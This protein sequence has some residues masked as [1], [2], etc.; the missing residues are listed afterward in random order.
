MHRYRDSIFD[1]EKKRHPFLLFMILFLLVLISAAM[2]FNHINNSR[3]NLVK[4][5]VTISTL[6]SSFENFRI[7]HISDLHGL[8]FGA[9]QERISAA[10]A[11]ANYD[12]VCIT[13]DV[14]TRDGD[15][16]AFLELISLLGNK[17]VYFIT[18]DE[19]PEPLLAYPHG[20]ESA[21]ADYILQAQAMGA[22]YLD[23]P[24]KITKGSG[25][26]W[27]SPEWV[28]TLD[29]EVS[30]AALNSRK[31]ELEKEP[32]TAERDAAMAA[33]DYQ[34]D[35][36]LRI[37]AARREIT[38]KD[39]HIALTHHP[40]QLSAMENLQEWSE[41]D[42]D[43]YVR[44]VSLVLAGHYVSGQWQLPLIGPLRVPVSSGLG[45]NGWFPGSAGVT[46]L[47]NF[48]GIPQYISPGLGASQAIGL[49]GFRFFNTPTVSIITLTTKLLHLS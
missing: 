23:A 6:P 1:S 20:N 44:T 10:I 32:P 16:S 36:L 37:R 49:P 3:V 46:G 28:Y 25:T 17:P 22:I 13:G 45:N 15:A 12:I 14:T 39:V 30:S 24:Q 47:S 4:Q 5:S 9:H 7:L 40:L 29:I 2:V 43:S 34:I 26:L 38:E 42:N 31:E 18:G 8:F 19:D 27:L 21:L 11:G 48:L 35:R 41:T 33:V